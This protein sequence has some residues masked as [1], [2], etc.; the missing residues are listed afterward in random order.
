MIRTVLRP[1]LSGS[2]ADRLF[3]G[4]VLL[5]L[6]VG[7]VLTVFEN[8]LLIW[9]GLI[10]TGALLLATGG[11]TLPTFWRAPLGRMLLAIPL[12][13]LGLAPFAF[14]PGTAAEFVLTTILPIVLAGGAMLG[15]APALAPGR[16]DL[17]LATATLGMAAAVLFLAVE[18]TLSALPGCPSI[19]SA[20]GQPGCLA[21]SDFNQTAC[22]LAVW[23]APLLVFLATRGRRFRAIAAAL[24]LAIGAAIFAGTSESAKLGFLAAAAA[25]ALCIA[26]PPRRVV[27]AMAVVWA[28][29]TVATPAIVPTLVRTVEASPVMDVLPASAVHRLAIWDMTAVLIAERPW[30]GWGFNNARKIGDHYGTIVLELPVGPDGTPPRVIETQVIPNHP[31]NAGLEWWIDLGALGTLA[32]T[33]VV[34][35]AILRTAPPSPSSGRI[36]A[37]GAAYAATLAAAVTIAQSAY[38]TW[39]PWWLTTVFI[40][41]FLVRAVLLEASPSQDGRSG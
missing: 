29:T 19:W 17:L 15:A 31:H 11:R 36:R 30:T 6:G 12:I 26:F 3:A 40:A 22:I 25:G 38:G 33:V 10:L 21:P 13:G 5:A 9:P 18:S 7:P 35:V 4:L 2:P 8:R 23:A 34:A 39:Q 32:L 14:E 41:A 28:L 37:A 27:Q 1:W 16:R 24:G 20:V